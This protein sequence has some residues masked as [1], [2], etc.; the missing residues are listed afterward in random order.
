M[1][2]GK[3]HDQLSLRSVTNLV[4]MRIGKLAGWVNRELI[5]SISHGQRAQLY[6]ST[7]VAW[8]DIYLQWNMLFAHVTKA[9]VTYKADRSAC[10]I[11]GI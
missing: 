1:T 8:K 9:I 4:A 3:R 2:D 6:A 11:S 7:R 10:F 5:D